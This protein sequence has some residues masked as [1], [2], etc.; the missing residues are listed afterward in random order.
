MLPVAGSISDKVGRVKTMTYA[1]VML[2]ICGPIMLILISKGNAF[3]AFLAQSALGV[4][5]SFFEGSLCAWMVENFPP[6]VRLTLASLGYD[7]AHATAAGFS[8][9]L[10]TYLADQVGIRSLGIIYPVFGI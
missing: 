7:I 9:V 8:P 3:L 5:L 10:A 2:S 6:E 1:A 4:L